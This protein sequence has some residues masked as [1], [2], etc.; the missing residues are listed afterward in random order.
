[1]AGFG[2]GHPDVG[3]TGLGGQMMSPPGAA[4][5]R[6][7][8]PSPFD[9]Y[10]PSESF[11]GQGYTVSDAGEFVPPENPFE[12]KRYRR[13]F[14]EQLD[15]PVGQDAYAGDHEANSQVAQMGARDQFT[16]FGY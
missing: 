2:A 12:S 11:A 8:R 3:A 16:Q 4:V 13:Q 15:K 9:G 10:A 14:Q 5:E 7:P 1:M 6:M